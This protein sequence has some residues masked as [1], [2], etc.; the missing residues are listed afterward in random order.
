MRRWEET[1][2]ADRRDQNER[3]NVEETEG[4]ARWQ[5]AGKNDRKKSVDDGWKEVQRVQ[6][7]RRLENETIIAHAY[8]QS[9]Y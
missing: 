6:M 9:V 1:D 5:L 4:D 3:E 2:S 8:Q 7:D